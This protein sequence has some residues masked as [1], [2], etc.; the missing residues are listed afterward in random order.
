MFQRP[1]HRQGCQPLNQVLD[2]IAQV[3]IQPGLKHLQEGVLLWVLRNVGS[4]GF[5][6]GFC[7]RHPMQSFTDQP[8]AEV[9]YVLS[10]SSQVLWEWVGCI[11][12]QSGIW[13]ICLYHFSFIKLGA[14]CRYLFK[15][16]NN[17]LDTTKYNLCRAKRINDLSTLCL[18]NNKTEIMRLSKRFVSFNKIFY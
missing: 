15:F 7:W 18:L 12:W 1:C 14:K 11:S 8:L 6:R 4:L 16:R 10:C 5:G 3:P 9:L 17:W 2:Q 13:C